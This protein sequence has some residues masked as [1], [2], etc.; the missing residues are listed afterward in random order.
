MTDHSSDSEVR[1]DALGST[2]RKDVREGV[3]AWWD[4]VAWF[5][6]T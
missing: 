1:A 3:D 6:L 5:E 4:E 2:V